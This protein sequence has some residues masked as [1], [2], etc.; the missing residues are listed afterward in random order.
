[1]TIVCSLSLPSIVIGFFPIKS[2][3]F[4]R[5]LLHHCLPIFFTTLYHF[6]DKKIPYTSFPTPSK[7]YTSFIVQKQTT[8]LETP[9]LFFILMHN[10]FINPYSVVFLLKRYNP[11]R[12]SPPHYP[13]NNPHQLGKR[14]HDWR[15]RLRFHS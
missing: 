11:L 4:L 2:K 10:F 9:G 12:P 7:L 8:H 15:F 5:I 6:A 14:N 1:M 13:L 3:Y